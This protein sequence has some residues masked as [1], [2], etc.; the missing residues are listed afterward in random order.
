MLHSLVSTIYSIRMK[1]PSDQFA[2][3]D[4]SAKWLEGAEVCAST[5]LVHFYSCDEGI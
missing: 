3:L 4:I 5:E 1:L 2:Q